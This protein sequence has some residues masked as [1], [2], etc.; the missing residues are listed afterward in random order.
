LS[1]GFED[2]IGTQ[3]RGNFLCL[4]LKDQSPR[5]FER[6]IVGQCQI[7]GLIK[8]DQSR[9]LRGTRLNCQQNEDL[10]NEDLQND[11]CQK[12]EAR[13]RHIEMTESDGHMPV[14]E[15]RLGAS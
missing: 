13:R 9:R 3:V 14:K 4:V 6:M 10:Q 5:S 1:V 2:R 12:L 8:T 7:D 15:K 11:E